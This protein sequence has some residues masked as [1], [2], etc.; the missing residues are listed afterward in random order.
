MH[1]A[2][3][4]LCQSRTQE[5]ATWRQY[6]SWDTRLHRTI[7][8]ATQNTPV[9]WIVRHAERPAPGGHLGPAT[10][11]PQAGARPSQLHRTRGDH[12]RHRKPR[13]ERRCS[14]NA[15][16]FAECRAQPLGAAVKPRRPSGGPSG[17]GMLGCCTFMKLM[18]IH[19]RPAQVRIHHERARRYAFHVNANAV[20]RFDRIS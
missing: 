5:A 19:L 15:Y 2:E 10:R 4:R 1:L 20:G 14:G 17:A 11:I 13:H 7:A 6:E 3:M 18:L 8:E 12:C 9:A 16:S